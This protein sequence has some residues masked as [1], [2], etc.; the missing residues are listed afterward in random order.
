MDSNE[1]VPNIIDLT[2]KRIIRDHP[3]LLLRLLGIPL[4]TPYRFEDAVVI[5]TEMRADHVFILQDENGK[6][7]GAF[8]WE[9]V[10]VPKIEDHKKWSFK[11]GMLKKQLGLPVCMMVMYLERGNY[12]TFPSAI[13]DIVGGLTT[14]LEFVSILL[15]EIEDRIRTGEL[16]EF[17]PLLYLTQN[18]SNPSIL[19]EEAA[20][21]QSAPLSDKTK[22]ELILL[23]VRAASRRFGSDI[24]RSIFKE[25]ASMKLNENDFIGEFIEEAAEIRAKE[26]AEVQIKG[27]FATHL[28]DLSSVPSNQLMEEL[29]RRLENAERLRSLRETTLRILTLRLGALPEGLIDKI[30]TS[31]EAWCRQLLDRGAVIES[32][33]ELNWE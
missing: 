17:A 29:S 18:D 8:Y 16:A 9:Y 22:D 23:A 7:T 28:K 31:D 20:I 32:L 33:T 6:D 1:K 27:F 2:I 4:T 21:I 19:E 11:W 5:P 24:V 12:A 15:W 30:N 25:K 26:I 13:V 3:S 14:K 10:L